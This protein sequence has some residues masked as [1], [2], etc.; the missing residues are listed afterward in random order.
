LKSD[1]Y[2]LHIASLFI[3]DRFYSATCRQ[4]CRGLLSFVQLVALRTTVWTHWLG[5]SYRWG[6]ARRTV[7][8]PLEPTSEPRW[9]A[10]RDRLGGLLEVRPLPPGTNLKRAFVA[11]MLEWLDGGWELGEFSSTGGTFFCTRGVERRMVC[12]TP[13]DPGQARAQTI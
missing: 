4:D 13:S 3:L 11:A 6:V 12:I 2:V 8:D 1:I 10:V 7:F 5:G 9:Y